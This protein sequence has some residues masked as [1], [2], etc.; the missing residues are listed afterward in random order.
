ML[1]GLLPCLIILIL[2]TVFSFQFMLT[3]LY[4]MIMKMN[5]YPFWMPVIR[6]GVNLFVVIQYTPPV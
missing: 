5:G 1:A 3:M 6:E 4:G 2:L